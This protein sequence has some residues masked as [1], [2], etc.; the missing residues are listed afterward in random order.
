MAAE[1]KIKKVICYYHRY[2]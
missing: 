1:N 2:I